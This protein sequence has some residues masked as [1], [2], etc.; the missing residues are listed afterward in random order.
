M[1]FLYIYVGHKADINPLK[2]DQNIQ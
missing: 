1:H 2:S